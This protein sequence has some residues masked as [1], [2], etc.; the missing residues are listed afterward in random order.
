MLVWGI[1]PDSGHEPGEK[2]QTGPAQAGPLEL[3]CLTPARAG[4]TDEPLDSLTYRGQALFNTPSMLR[5]TPFSPPFFYTCL[6]QTCPRSLPVLAYQI[7]SLCLEITSGSTLA[8]PEPWRARN[9]VSMRGKLDQRVN[10][11]LVEVEECIC[12]SNSSMPRPT[13]FMSLPA[14]KT[15]KGHLLYPLGG[16]IKLF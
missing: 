5:S 1:E 7:L 3:H 10:P 15:S 11:G 6:R 9:G 2:F 13:F 14:C 4:S 8:C 16:V 12:L